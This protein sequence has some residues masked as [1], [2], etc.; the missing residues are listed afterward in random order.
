MKRFWVSVGFVTALICI[1][2]VLQAQ[3]APQGSAEQS[4]KPAAPLLDSPEVQAHLAKAG[5]FAGK[6]FLVT[7][8]NQCGDIRNS[9]A[10]KLYAE[11]TKIFDDFYFVGE[12]SVSAFALTTSDGIVLIDSMFPYSPEEVILPGM[13]KLGL[14]PGTIKYV[15]VTHGHGDHSLG[16]KYFQD[17][18]HARV[19]TSAAEWDFME[20]AKPRPGGPPEMQGEYPKRDMIVTDGQKLTLGDTTITM[21]IT[22]GHTAG[23]V[24][25][26]V[27][28]KDN[29]IPHVLGLWGGT[30]PGT[31][32]EMLKVYPLAVKHFFEYTDPAKVDVTIS[33]HP[34]VDN[35][36]ELMA[37]LRNRKP[38]EPNPF[39]IGQENFKRYMNVI[40]ECS[41]VW[42]ARELVR[43]R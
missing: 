42:L 25:I 37:G 14:N 5:E 10:S 20:R 43:D 23:V 31:G 38:G 21:V 35:S 4:P 6:D 13:K 11:P 33:N 30:G 41:E 39:V 3:T 40:G 34:F 2:A 15:I 29:G 9:S 12:Q 18:Y 17:K 24:S 22:P 27:P 32:M 8:R 36:L 16:A 28:V 1:S 19:L 26:I 7:Y